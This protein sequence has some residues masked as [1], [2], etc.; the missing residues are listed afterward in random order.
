MGPTREREGGMGDRRSAKE[1]MKIHKI[2]I[3]SK[4][5]YNV[6]FLKKLFVPTRY[7]MRKDTMDPIK[8]M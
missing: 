1:I 6:I 7:G 4:V 8:L 2:E 5:C 3:S